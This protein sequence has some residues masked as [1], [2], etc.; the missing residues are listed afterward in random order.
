MLRD[1]IPDIPGRLAK[2]MAIAWLDLLNESDDDKPNPAE[3]IAMNSALERLRQSFK[4]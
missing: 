4:R 3:L 2:K 1:A